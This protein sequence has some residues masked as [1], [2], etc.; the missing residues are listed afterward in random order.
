MTHTLKALRLNLVNSLSSSGWPWAILAMT[1]LVNLAIFAV[2]QNIPTE[3]RQTAALSSLYVVALIANLQLWTQGFSFAMG[4]SLTRKAFFGGAVLF[5]LIQS[6]V[7]GVAL[8]ALARVEA[9][10]GGW[11]MH[12]KFFRAWFLDQSN[13]GVQFLMY[14]VPFA[15]ISALGMV[16]GVVLKR[17][18]QSGVYALTLGS[19]VVLGGAAVL[20]TWREWWG[21][22]GR[23]F[24][25]SNIVGL[26]AGYPALLA[27][28][29]AGLAYLWLRRATP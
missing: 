18:G 9:A 12:L 22:L 4:L 19:L 10:T 26:S 2:L 27:V 16:I 7:A 11:G 3:D 24:T 29:F 13:L 5:I 25:E 23:F 17:W 14:A 6:V 21:D 1:F 8:T 15:M 28:A 20:V